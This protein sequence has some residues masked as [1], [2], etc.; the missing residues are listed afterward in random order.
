ME[1]IKLIGAVIGMIAIMISLLVMALNGS[2]FAGALF[3]GFVLLYSRLI[4][5]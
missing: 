2:L 4:L 1:T 5:G 3:V